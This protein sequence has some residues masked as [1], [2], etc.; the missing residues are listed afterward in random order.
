MHRL[1]LVSIF[2]LVGGNTL[3]AQRGYKSYL[4]FGPSVG[5]TNYKGDLDDDFTL[6]FTRPGFGFGLFYNFHPH[7]RLRAAFT[8]GWIGAA[9]SI[10]V[11]R[12]RKWR[13][14][15]FRSHLTEFSLQFIYEFFASPRIY[16]YRPQFSP[17]IFGGVAVFNFDPRAKASDGKWYRLQPLGTEGQFLNDPSRSY[18]KPY[19][20]TQV[21]IPMGIGGRWRLSDQWDLWFEIGL[22][23]TFTDYLDDV[24]DRYA[25][26]D[27]MAAQMGPIAAELSDRSGYRAQGSSGFEANDVRGFVNQDDWYVY[28]GFT[29]SYIIDPGDRC[30]KFR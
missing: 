4:A 16:R 25:P 6:K 8:Q 18:P 19:A 24:S 7:L 26:L 2:C 27:L 3:W 28:T 17:F 11:N 10:S 22:R 20:L 29:V 14:L 13:N 12:F 9:D 1:V 30:P 15:H 21:S 23:K 5:I